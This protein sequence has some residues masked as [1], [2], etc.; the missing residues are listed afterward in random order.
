M[1]QVTKPFPISQGP[2]NTL[3]LQRGTTLKILTPEAAKML[4]QKTGM[5]FIEVGMCF[6]IGYD[7]EH[8]RFG[9]FCATVEDTTKMIDRGLFEVIGH[10][11]PAKNPTLHKQFMHVIE[12]LEL[13]TL[14]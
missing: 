2:G 1:R 10:T 12:G 8:V 5:S 4:Q 7:G 3:R 13:V 11:D 9:G 6:P 14:N